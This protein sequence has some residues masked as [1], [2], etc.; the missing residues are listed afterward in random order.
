MSKQGCDVY[1]SKKKDS[2]FIGTCL[3]QLSAIESNPAVCTITPP[4]TA[5]DYNHDL[6]VFFFFVKKT[7]LILFALMLIITVV[8]SWS[9]AMRVIIL[10]VLCR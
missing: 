4:T 9:V 7:M 5:Y 10:L 1:L 6:L 2:C 3:I 8:L